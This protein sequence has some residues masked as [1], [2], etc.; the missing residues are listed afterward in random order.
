MGEITLLSLLVGSL[1]LQAIALGGWLRWQQWGIQQVW[2]EE[3][4]LTPYE[5]KDTV[6]VASQTSTGATSA[7]KKNG[8]GKPPKDP[9]LVGWEFKIVRANRELFRDREIFQQLCEEE[10]QAGWILLEKLDDRRVRFKRPIA[11]REIV[12]SDVLAIDP[13]RSH[14]GSS[15][16]PG[17]WM[18]TIVGL[19]LLVLPAYLGF[20]LVSATLNKQPANFSQPMRQTAPLTSPKAP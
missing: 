9:R 10:S 2:E 15:V 18:G 19:L 17:L 6:R 1:G 16:K 12:K 11:L 13:Y 5:S 14:Y 8:L 4:T 3:E 7:E 20:R